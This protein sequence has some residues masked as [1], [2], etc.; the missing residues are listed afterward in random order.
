[1]LSGA[2]KQLYPHDRS[3]GRDLLICILTGFFIT[4]FLIVFRPFG[5][6]NWNAPFLNLKIAGYGVITALI[7]LTRYFV[8][9]KL[10]RNFEKSETWTLGLELGTTFITISV[11]AIAN[12]YYLNLIVP[13]S[14]S[15]INFINMATYTFLIGI[16]PVSTL[17]CLNYILQLNKYLV[18]ASALPT[19]RQPNEKNC[20]SICFIAENGIDQI[21]MHLNDLVFIEAEDNYCGVNH[22]NDGILEKRLLRNTLTHIQNQLQEDTLVRCHRSFMINLNQVEKVIG[23]AQGYRFCIR[24]STLQVP[25]GRKYNQVVG[26]FKSVNIVKDSG[27][28]IE[29]SAR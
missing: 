4:L 11:I 5:I 22:Y 6:N 26:Q 23:N 28:V 12:F 24:A 18:L 10:F 21:S 13:V 19:Y 29:K 27:S 7:L 1:M 9:P 17:I 14:V 25:V 8:I 16:F 15:H 2:L 3:T 20:G